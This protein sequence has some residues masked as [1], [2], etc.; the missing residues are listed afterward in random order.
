MSLCGGCGALAYVELELPTAAIGSNTPQFQHAGFGDVAFKRNRHDLFSCGVGVRWQKHFHGRE[1]LHIFRN[2]FNE[3]ARRVVLARERGE[4]AEVR[5]FADYQSELTLRQLDFG[6][7]FQTK[8]HYSEGLHRRRE[9]GYSRQRAFDSQ[10]RKS[11][12]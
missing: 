2:L 4:E 1:F 10:D 5:G 12:V 6:T 11:V 3:T 8:R 9:A 7:F